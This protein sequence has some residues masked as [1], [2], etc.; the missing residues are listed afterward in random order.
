MFISIWSLQMY[1][2][3]Q[4]LK[5]TS[6]SS[7]L[8]AYEEGSPS[9]PW[10]RIRTKQQLALPQWTD[11]EPEPCAIYNAESASPDHQSTQKSPATSACSRW[12]Y[13]LWGLHVHAH[14]C[15]PQ[16][17]QS[18][19]I[20]PSACYFCQKVPCYFCFHDAVQWQQDLG[21]Q[22]CLSPWKNS[23][24]SVQCSSNYRLIGDVPASRGRA[25]ATACVLVGLSEIMFVLC[26][27]D[28]KLQLS[29]G[30]SL[31]QGLFSQDSP[32]KEW[33]NRSWARFHFW[34]KSGLYMCRTSVGYLLVHGYD[35]NNRSGWLVNI[36][37]L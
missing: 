16:G 32:G 4:N 17:S 13:P 11:G 24:H 3:F 14:A 10:E 36:P 2:M 8:A 27:F 30:T 7:R 28:T 25:T 22:P 12:C 15:L 1:S 35:T 34:I 21:R 6:N 26:T 18:S 31:F 20:F 33:N 37:V 9:S 29:P 5:L 23:Q 19:I